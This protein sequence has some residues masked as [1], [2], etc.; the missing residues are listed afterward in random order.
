MKRFL[1]FAF[2]SYYPDGGWGDFVDAFNTV[3]GAKEAAAELQGPN[4]EHQ[5][6]VDLQKM[7]VVHWR[8]FSSQIDWNDG[9]PPE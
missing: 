9:E 6:I 1:L 5:Q 4:G 8:G 3:E 2:G 7:K